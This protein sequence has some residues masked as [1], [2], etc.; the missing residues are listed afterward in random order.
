MIPNSSES[1]FLIPLTSTPQIF[2][3][4]LAGNDY[5]L[6]VRWNDSDEGGWIM[7]ILDQNTQTPLACNI[8]FITGADMLEG[9]EYLGIEGSLVAYTNGDTWAVP[10][11][12]NLGIDANLYFFTSV[13]N[14]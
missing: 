1:Q 5:T 13:P 8:P 12:T 3:I 9:L 10:T 11:F 4:N 14:G 7:D 6:N 2:N